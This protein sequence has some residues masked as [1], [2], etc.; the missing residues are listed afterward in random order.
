[1]LGPTRQWRKRFISILVIN[2][3]SLANAAAEEN[4]SAACSE[5][6]QYSLFNP[7]PVR[8]LREFQPDRPDL[9]DNP[10]TVDAGHV[11]LEADLVNYTLSRPDVEGTVTEKFLFGATDIRVGL[12]NNIEVDALVQPIN[13]LHTR[14]IRPSRDT[15]AAGPDT[16]EIGAK[17]NLY[18]MTRSR[19]QVR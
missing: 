7:T 18:G 16:L 14:F 17:I 6:D 9:T 2:A 11:Q 1:M 12:T 15:W 19:G 10:F 3:V 5:K 8:C 4:N 13:A